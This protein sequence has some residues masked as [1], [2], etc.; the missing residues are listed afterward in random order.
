MRLR[1]AGG[2]AGRC[3]LRLAR[4]RRGASAVQYIL[5][6][7]CVGLVA[8]IAFRNFG[9]VLLRMTG[10]EAEHVRALTPDCPGLGDCV[11]G[12]SGGA[13]AGGPAPPSVVSQAAAAP[14][15]AEEKPS[16]GNGRTPAL[17]ALHSPA[18]PRAEERPRA[19]GTPAEGEKLGGAPG[20]ADLP[21]GAEGVGDAPGGGGAPSG[22]APAA[23][24]GAGAAG[25]GSG[26]SPRP[27]VPPSLGQRCLG[28]NLCAGSVGATVGFLQGMAPGGFLANLLPLPEG[29]KKNAAYQYWNGAGQ[30]AGGIASA[31][32]G[33]AAEAV[34][35]ALDLTGIGAAVGVPINVAGAVLVANA[36]TAAVA[37]TAQM[38]K[39]GQMRSQG[40]PE[41]PPVEP[42]A[43][44]NAP[45]ERPAPANEKPPEAKST[46][47]QPESAG[48]VEPSYG[49]LQDPDSVGPGKDFTA[50]QKAK[51]IQENMKRNGGVVRSDQSGTVL[52]SPGKSQ[53]GVTP[54]PNEWQIDHIVPKDKGGTNSY[55]NAQVL[56]RAENRAKS[57]N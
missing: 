51:I 52:K 25:G 1:E 55:R 27:S 43:G 30:V 56:S 26:A 31:T 9:D 5:V 34:G 24:S 36:A 21:L 37:G 40:A 32:A 47:G 44:E 42:N 22:G 10:S 11:G 19:E 7:G 13:G 35:G 16:S 46:P 12:G 38:V 8:L 15:A 14:P 33:T 49:H 20:G 6:L 29:V 39:A 17:A 3:L 4:D 45:P 50:A 23:N 2:R 54:D 48:G 41:Q 18:Q 28:S 57:N 53:R